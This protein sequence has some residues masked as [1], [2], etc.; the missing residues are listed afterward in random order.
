MASENMNK[1]KDK[2]YERLLSL[3]VLV[4]FEFT[5]WLCGKAPLFL[6]MFVASAGS[7]GHCVKTGLF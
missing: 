6:N 1:K 5:T 4:F 3:I 2:H 7:T